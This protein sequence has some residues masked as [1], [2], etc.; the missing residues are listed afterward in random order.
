[1]YNN[2]VTYTTQQHLWWKLNTNMEMKDVHAEMYS[3]LVSQGQTRW[4]CA[5]MVLLQTV[6]NVKL[7]AKE[8][9]V[10]NILVPVSRCSS[11]DEGAN[12]SLIT[13]QRTICCNYYCKRK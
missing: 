1:M 13:V 7:F 8:S 5:H 10:K 6:Y 11:F 3:F 4:T 12:Y 2:K 9:S